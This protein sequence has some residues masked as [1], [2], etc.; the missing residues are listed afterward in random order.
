MSTKPEAG[1]AH[2]RRLLYIRCQVA[3]EVAVV[4]LVGVRLLVWWLVE[5]NVSYEVRVVVVESR[6]DDLVEVDDDRV[7]VA[8]DIP[9]HAVVE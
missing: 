8:V 9:H 4:E 6:Y 2:V 3:E 1:S 7:P 5:V